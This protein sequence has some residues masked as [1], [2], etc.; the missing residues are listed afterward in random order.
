MN[1][2]LFKAI[3]NQAVDQKMFVNNPLMFYLVSYVYITNNIR[4][5][6]I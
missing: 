6:K 1:L 5:E 4:F 2:C 3:D